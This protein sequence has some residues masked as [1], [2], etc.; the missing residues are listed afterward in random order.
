MELRNA[1][2]T[3]QA[4]MNPIFRYCIDEFMVVYLDDILIF[5]ESR[6]YRLNHLRIVLTR[7][8]EHQLYLGSN[9]FEIMKEE[10]DFL[11]L[12]VGRKGIPIRE[13]RNKLTREWTIANS[14]NEV[15]SF[16]GLAQFF[17]QFISH[18]SHISAPLT[19][20]TRT[21]GIIG[22][23]NKECDK[24]FKCLEK[25][26]ISAPIMQTPDWPKPFICH[27]DASQLAVGG[28]LTQ[29]GADNEEHAISFSFRRRSP[30]EE[31]YSPN[32]RELLGLEYFFQRFRCYL[33]RSESEILTDNQVLK[34]FF[35]K[36]ESR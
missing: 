17:R 2:A 35:S 5:S 36:I 21:N 6:K 18:F 24:Y 4:L 27:T 23:W 20:L 12:M 26:L 25:F 7:I 28:K 22:Q 33:E 29:L 15:R 10:T 1:P 9:K 31:N 3:C 8:K 32:D 14:I 13:D 34:Y 30:A 11:G 16:L 19:N